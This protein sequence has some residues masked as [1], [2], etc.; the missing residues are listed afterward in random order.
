MPPTNPSTL[1]PNPSA[2]A[3]PYNSAL[4][5]WLSVDPLS[6][7]YPNLSPYTYC[8]DNPVR[9]VDVD[10]RE[11]WIVGEDG[12]R[13]KYEKGTIY[14]EEGK[15]YSP[16]SGS[17]IANAQNAIDVLKTTKTGNKLISTFEG[18]NNKDVFIKWNT[19]S[20][21]DNLTTDAATG[22]FI[23]QTIL[24][25]STGTDL[26]TTAGVQKNA[27]TDL[28]HEFSHAYDNAKNIK[29]LGDWCTEGNG[30][31]RSEW[32]AVYHEN[33]IR[34]ELGVPYRCGYTFKN[35]SGETFFVRMLNRK[36][37]P[38]MPKTSKWIPIENCVIINN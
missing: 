25:N 11:V 18:S 4:S 15:P 13:Y 35:P 24:W 21:C 10:G 26:S 37:E 31:T 3:L 2:A 16:E 34:K 1:H 30:G 7:K 22:A 38:Y 14:T 23:N 29:G 9:L 20:K 19:E 32:R 8:A 6:D 12:N 5:L 27:I 36:G 33:L 28:G 17:F